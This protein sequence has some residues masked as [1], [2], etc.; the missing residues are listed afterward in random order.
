MVSA[1]LLLFYTAYACKALSRVARTADQSSAPSVLRPGSGNPHA[2]LS[3]HIGA[4]K[5]LTIIG[6]SNGEGNCSNHEQGKNKASIS[7]HKLMAA[8]TGRNYPIILVERARNRKTER[9]YSSHGEKKRPR[10]QKMHQDNIVL[11]GCKYRPCPLQP[12]LPNRG[13]GNEALSTITMSH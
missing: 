9:N 13:L 12:I 2:F 7:N 5:I 4:T 10:S 6:K 3:N 11:P 1:E 8:G